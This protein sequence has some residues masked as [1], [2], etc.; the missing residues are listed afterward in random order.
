MRVVTGLIAANRRAS[1]TRVELDGEP[2]AELDSEV[3]LRHALRE[4]ATLDEEQLEA[5]RRD[6]TFV[7]ARRAAAIL[8]R[9][10][11]RSV[12]ELRGRL[13]ERGFDDAALE[14][15]IDYF[16]EKG[17]LDDARFARA[18]VAQRLR[19]QKAGPIKI[20]NALKRLGVEEKHI[21][22]AL[23]ADPGAGEEHQRELARRFIERWLERLEN[24][25]PVRRRRKLRAALARAG[26]R[27]DA[28]YSELDEA[29]RRE[30]S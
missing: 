21:A 24:D 14:R 30:E 16:T 4:G 7:R 18:F 6:D 3:V 27:P 5:L 23:E 1:R 28:Y 15:T 25:D 19:T 20:A 9:T 13:I 17:D 2:W 26:F 10:R 8:L 29:L 11:Q 22:A 12:A